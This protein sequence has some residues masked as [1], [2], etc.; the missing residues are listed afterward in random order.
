MLT[1]RK[2][3]NAK[4]QAKRYE[5]ADENDHGRGTLLVRVAPTG[6]KTF[7]FRYYN[8]GKVRR[9]T[10]GEYGNL[11]SQLTLA[12]AR[13]KT[14]EAVSKLEQGVDPAK[15]EI[16]K[17]SEAAKAPTVTNL[18]LEYLEKW[19]KVRKRSWREDE[20]ILVRDVLP[21][22]G[23]KKARDVTRRD[24]VLLLDGIVNRGAQIAAN[25]T[26]ALIR[27]MFNFGV[28]RSILEFN[29]CAGVQAPSK[30]HQKDRVLSDEEIVQFWRG[31]E[32]AGMSLA[33]KLVLRMMLVT[34]QRLG[35]INQLCRE[36]IEEDWWTIPASIAK[37]GKA[38]RVPLSSLALSLLAES[39]KIAG[40]QYIFASPKTGAGKERPMSTTALS[41]A[42]RKNHEL[43]GLPPFTPHDLRRTAATHIG[44]LGFN[45]LI[46]SKILNHVEGG[47]TA[48]YDRHTYDNEKREALHAWSAKLERLFSDHFL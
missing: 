4:S 31:L 46:I 8:N 27:K 1:D 5:M 40:T 11:P 38:H 44:M 28:S 13:A 48:I 17:K 16:Q 21:V 12:Q 37:N 25:R 9:L 32:T 30:E 14:A 3:A 39:E 35:E 34:G 36:Q 19:A 47:V 7:V 18:A 20:R 26:L 24:V 45:R 6:S 41:H 23:E 43:L 10:L 2:I 15:E 22:W 29:P 42:L 33:T